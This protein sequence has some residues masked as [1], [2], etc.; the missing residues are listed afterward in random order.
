MKS[1]HWR[2]QFP[3]CKIQDVADG[4]GCRIREVHCLLGATVFAVFD[5]CT[6]CLKLVDS[7]LLQQLSFSSTFVRW[8]HLPLDAVFPKMDDAFEHGANVK[9]VSTLLTHQAWFC[10]VKGSCIGIDIVCHN[11]LAVV[12]ACSKWP[13]TRQVV[14]FFEAFQ[15]I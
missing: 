2:L 14:K 5:F 7:C 1:N 11:A 12:S 13:S 3:N 10:G 9:T 6:S 15:G 4:L 8:E